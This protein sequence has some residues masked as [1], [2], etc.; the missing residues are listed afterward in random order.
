MWWSNLFSGMSPANFFNFSFLPK[1]LS[2]FVQGLE[3]TLLLSV[4]S[5]G[6]AVIPALALAL[7]R[8]SRSRIVRNLSGAYIAVF[9]STPMMVQLYIIFY[10]LF[11]VIRIP[12]VVILGFI[13]LSRFIPGV[14]A[15][16]LNSSAYVAEI[17]RAG[18]LAVDGGQ[19]EAARS[20]GLS[21]WQSMKLVVLPQAIKNILP[22]LGNEFVTVIKESSIVSV[23][24]LADLMFRTNDV[25]ALTFKSLACLAIAALCYF[26]MT[27]TGGRLIALAERK[28]NHG[29]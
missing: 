12:S 17:I 25:I 22:A 21:S 11:S 3:Y 14:V 7:M 15:L 9:R 27:F 2:F 5:V 24:G 10:G 13:D 4:I 23:I 8:L 1:Y 18:I 6:L 19:N 20:L 16:A 28:M 29:K 26:A